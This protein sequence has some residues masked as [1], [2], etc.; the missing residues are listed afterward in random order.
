VFSRTPS[1]ANPFS[2]A[3]PAAPA[4]SAAA[5]AAAASAAVP[6]PALLPGISPSTHCAPSSCLPDG[7]VVVVVAL[8]SYTAQRAEELSF[9]EGDM[10]RVL[11]QAESGW[12]TG[13]VVGSSP[14]RTG[15]V[16][17]TYFRPKA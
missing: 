13:R 14:P 7:S 11:A 4:A 17:Y 12:W 16:P 1:A 6:L 9:K 8:G 2:V 5:I 3:K 15:L 10:L